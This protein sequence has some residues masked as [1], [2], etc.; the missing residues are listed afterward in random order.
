[1]WCVGKPDPEP[2]RR[3]AELIRAAA[4]DC[5]VVEDA[6]NGVGAGKAAGMVACWGW[7]GTHSAEDL[8]GAGADW[9]VGS[10]VDVRATVGVVVGWR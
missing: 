9:V 6:P 3:G 7:W 1:M 8:R 5:V 4:A 2:Y 10:L